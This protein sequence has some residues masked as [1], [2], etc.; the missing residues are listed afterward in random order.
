M[1][2]LALPFSRPAAGGSVAGAAA[3]IAIAWKVFSKRMRTRDTLAQLR[4]LDD[5][6]LKDIGL[7]RSEI[8]PTAMGMRFDRLPRHH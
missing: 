2:E 3:R 1:A 7:H 4:A 6:T 5:R 8:V